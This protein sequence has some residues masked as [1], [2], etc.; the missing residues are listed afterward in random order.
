MPE[1]GVSFCSV[2]LE[3]KIETIISK[4][5]LPVSGVNLR[6]GRSGSFPSAYA[7]DLEYSDFDPGVTRVRRER[8]LL[9]YL[10]SVETAQHKGTGVL[11]AAVRKVAQPGSDG[12]PK[13][14]TSSLACVLEVSDQGLRMVDRGR[15]K[16]IRNMPSL[17]IIF[18][19]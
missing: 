3:K 15:P 14:H 8:F 7:V 18:F 4:L 11:A 19:C 9:R 17:K 6:S 16:V 5:I 12:L 1:T 10:G 2:R 13:S